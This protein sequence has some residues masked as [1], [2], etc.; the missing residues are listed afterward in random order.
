MLFEGKRFRLCTDARTYIMGVL[1]VTPDSFSDGGAYTDAQKAIDRALQMQREGADLIDVGAES[2]AP[3]HVPVPPAQEIA[4]LQAVLPALCA[5]LDVPVSVD[6]RHPET[7]EWAL[8]QGAA[9][10]NDVSGV[11]CGE[12]AEA[13]RRYDAGWIVT[14]G[15]DAD[16]AGT[17]NPLPQ[18]ADF[19]AAAV[20]FAEKAGLRRTQLCLD[21]G[22]GFGKS[23]KGDLRVLRD[24]RL[25]RP[26]CAVLVGASRKRVIGTLS[27]ETDPLRRLPGTIAAHTAA[28]A[29][30]ADIL[31]V[32]DVAESV[33]ASRVADALYRAE[34]VQ[35]PGRILLRDLRVFAYHGVNPEE[36]EYGQTFLLD[37]EME[38]DF[39]AAVAGDDVGDTV[40]YAQAAKTLQKAL[41]ETRYDLI[42][43]AA[44]AAARALLCAY[45]AI[46]SVRLRLKKPDAPMKAQCAWAGVEIERKRET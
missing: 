12:M 39:T 1:N 46:R 17:D 3:G 13:V 36:K 28:I 25:L 23:R 40:S 26:P 14:H 11:L 2:T 35:S 38:T 24:L 18:I 15:M 10:I 29:G 16:D 21:P 19:F 8:E 20:R 34:A 42:E 30:G 43:T 33:Q 22:I 7:A 37:V 41:T 9:I 45:P 31:R 4:R 32:H 27:G 5:K 44:D 6:T